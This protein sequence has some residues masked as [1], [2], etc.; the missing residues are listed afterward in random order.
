MTMPTMTMTTLAEDENQ[1]DQ[2]V[3]NCRVAGYDVDEQ[4]IRDSLA[5]AEA[6]VLRLVLYQITGDEEL[7]HMKVTKHEIR[8]GVLFDY[9]LSGEDE[10]IVREKALKH[11]LKGPRDAPLKPS[12]DEAFRLMDLFS[13]IPMKDKPGEPSFDYDVVARPLRLP[14]DLLVRCI[15][16]ELVFV[17]DLGLDLHRLGASLN[18][19]DNGRNGVARPYFP[20]RVKTAP[21]WLMVRSVHREEIGVLRHDHTQVRSCTVFLPRFL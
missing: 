21:T 10:E 3:I 13:D 19:T 17:E 4:F 11:I 18:H 7:A 14:Y 9:R 5:E 16:S 2:H 20:E 12:K 15:K 8:G 6:N 1:V